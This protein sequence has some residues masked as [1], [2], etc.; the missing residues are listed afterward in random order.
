MDPAGLSRW[1]VPRTQTSVP[2]S[3]SCLFDFGFVQG[4]SGPGVV[5]D[6]PMVMPMLHVHIFAKCP[7]AMAELAACLERCVDGTLPASYTHALAR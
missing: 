3:W 6:L 2:R 4:F 1:E 5:P 7:T